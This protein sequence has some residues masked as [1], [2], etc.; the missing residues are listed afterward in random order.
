MFYLYDMK[1]L[2]IGHVWPEPS[3]SAAG[4][5]MLQIINV[6]AEAGGEVH[7]A[8]TAQQGARSYELQS[9][10]VKTHEIKL[11]DSGFDA[12]VKALNPKVVVYDRFMVEEQFGWRIAEN[13][14]DA[15]RILDTEDL[16]GLRNA[17]AEALKKKQPS[18]NE[19][20]INDTAKREIASIYRCDL[21]LIISEVEMEL[22]QGF[23][24]VPKSLLLYLPFMVEKISD[25]EVADWK[26]FEART[27]FMTI[28]NF[29]HLPN[30]DGV[31]YLKEEIWPLIRQKLP[32]AVLHI[33]GAYPSAKVE[34]LQ[35]KKDGF[36]I[37]GYVENSQEVFK[38]SRVCLAAL[39]IGAG[40]KGKILEAMQYGTPCV[41]TSIGAEG[42]QGDF[43]FNGSI[44][45][46]AENFA[47][48][49]ITLYTEEEKWQKAQKNGQKIVNNRFL[50]QH[51]SPI[52]RQHIEE[53]QNSLEAHRLNNFTGS[54]LRHQSLQATK[55]MSKWI[56]EKN[57]S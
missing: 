23:F 26:P 9:L 44:E 27:D 42:M 46:T 5:R 25:E 22:L 15:L 56:E 4:S 16:H 35:N 50:A 3:S 40:L 30:Y 18:T 43:E 54:M 33:Y 10:T 39:R 13:C 6:F 52:L 32:Q 48:A 17:R 24:S 1:V 7:F 2:I 47:A 31:L 45:N 11:N 55:F 57:K 14:P 28:G 51:W 53:L 19:Y 34:Q 37:H 8:S 38:N 49:A 41:T 21:S 12:F 29:K 20:L 36:L